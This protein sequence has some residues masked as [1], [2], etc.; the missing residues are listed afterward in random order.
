MSRREAANSISNRAAAM[1]PK[2]F[3]RA[4]ED[5]GR[6]VGASEER[7]DPGLTH[8]SHSEGVWMR[9]DSELR[10]AT[11]FGQVLRTRFPDPSDAVAELIRAQ[12]ISI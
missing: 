7:K 2:L 9:T 10:D 8:R 3:G 4:A 11:R 6:G 1:L 12:V 5:A